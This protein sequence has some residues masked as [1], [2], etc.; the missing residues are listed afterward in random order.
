VVVAGAIPL[1]AEDEVSQMR[2]LDAK[3]S[4]LS[5]FFLVGTTLGDRPRK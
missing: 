3:E 4:P 2:G 5:A 1:A